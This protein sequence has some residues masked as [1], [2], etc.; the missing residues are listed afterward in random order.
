[1]IL[2]PSKQQLTIDFSF[3]YKLTKEKVLLFNNIYKTNCFKLPFI[4]ICSTTNLYTIFNVLFRLVNKEDKTTYAWVLEC[5]EE[6][7]IN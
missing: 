2:L 4:N 3:K 6:L 5:V 7:C 1:M